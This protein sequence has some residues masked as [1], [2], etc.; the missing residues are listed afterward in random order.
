M[1]K[2]FTRRKVLAATGASFAVGSVGQVSATDAGLESPPD[3]AVPDI[4]VRNNRG[5][6]T[7]LE[8][9]FTKV[10]EDTRSPAAAASKRYHL[11]G[12]GSAESAASET[13]SLAEGT[14]EVS[15]NVDGEATETTTV[16][17]P[18]GGFPEWL[19]VSVRVMPG[20]RL[21]VSKIEA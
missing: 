20:N 16:I 6:S 9:E 13:V 1:S 10:P 8:V 18:E 19:G 3:H 5:E 4:T 7:T 15:A 11:A 12:Q 2:K 21:V 17:L 14:Y